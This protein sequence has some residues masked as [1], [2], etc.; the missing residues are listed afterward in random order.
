MTVL[1]SCSNV[2]S[3]GEM[4]DDRDG[5]IW[6]DSDVVDDKVVFDGKACFVADGVVRLSGQ[7]ANGV[8]VDV[9]VY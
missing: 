1:Q 2:L 9:V 7:N 4:R 5:R 3:I 6:C 8:W